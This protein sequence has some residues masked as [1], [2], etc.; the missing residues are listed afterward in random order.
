MVVCQAMELDG[1]KRVQLVQM[2]GT[3]LIGFFFLC[4]SINE[5]LL[6]ILGVDCIP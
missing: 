2:L 4:I 1:D 5:V 3:K 6:W